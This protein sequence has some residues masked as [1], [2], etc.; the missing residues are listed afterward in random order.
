MSVFSGGHG[1]KGFGGGAGDG[2]QGVSLNLTALMD[3]LS[4]LLFFLMASYAAQS[5]EVKE[6]LDMQLPVSSS[7]LG[8][9]PGLSVAITP[10]EIK[11]AGES[12]AGVSGDKI[13]GP[14]EEEDKVVG[15]YEAL[16]KIH[17]RRVA[18]GRGEAPNS[19]VV[20]V[21]ADRATDSAVLMKVL[22]TA[23][24]AGFVSVRFG[25]LPP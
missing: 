21:L 6:K 18:A 5:A 13:V 16:R 22:K 11:V 7:Q 4:N 24:M 3:I 12:V 20:L 9:E 19:D 23:G 8:V 1:L 15:V 10:T 17:D 14:V 2:I 25:V